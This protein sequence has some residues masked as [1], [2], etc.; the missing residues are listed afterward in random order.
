ME[1]IAGG[2]KGLDIRDEFRDSPYGWSQDAI[3]GA[4]QALQVA[5]IIKA[6]DERGKGIDFKSLERKMIGKSTFKVEST[7]IT[8]PQRIQIRK[9]RNI[10]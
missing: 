4:L 2:K 7:T 1:N 9:H 6:V 8:T 10:K 5:G 3:D